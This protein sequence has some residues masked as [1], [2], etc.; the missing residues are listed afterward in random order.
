MTDPLGPILEFG[1]RQARIGLVIGLTGTMLLHGGGA[2]RGFTTLAELR[3]F[4]ERV[5]VVVVD[6]LRAQYDIDLTPPPEVKPPPAP[7]PEPEPEPPPK[8]HRAPEAQTPPPAPAEAA[9]VLTT[10]PQPDDAPL[11]MT[12][13]GIVSGQA[14]RFPG[15]RT[16]SQ[17][18]STKPVMTRP[19]ASGVPNG[20]G[21]ATAP[22]APEKSQARS[23]LPTERNWSCGFPAEADMEQINFAKVTL[24]VT[25]A[26]DG[27]AKKVD[28]L[29]DPGYGFGKLAR[30]CA[31]R[32]QYT[33]GLD[34]SGQAI[35]TTTPPFTV[36]F[37]R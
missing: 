20:T 23:A 8:A 30:Q 28:V 27:K 16:S 19:V 4:S 1:R 25:V 9:K 36:R 32:K 6:R 14:D 37:T 26:A 21:T 5:R 2:V 13:W 17:G 10:D 34:R 18:K 31:F 29:N 7:E 24:V 35:T 12:G 33:P 15:G 11:D 3:L 22:A